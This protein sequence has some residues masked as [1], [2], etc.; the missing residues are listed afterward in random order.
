VQYLTLSEYLDI[1]LTWR[2]DYERWS[3]QESANA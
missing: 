2:I 3:S 1:I